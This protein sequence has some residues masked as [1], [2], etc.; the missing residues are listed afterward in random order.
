MFLGGRRFLLA[1]LVSIVACRKVFELVG[2]SDLCS[3]S[4]VFDLGLAEDDVRVRAWTLV[5]VRLL[6]DEQNILRLSDGHSKNSWN[7]FQTEFGH[8]LS[9]F[10]L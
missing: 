8:G 4:Q 2:G 1:R 5:D 6:D 10:F 3:L 9:G 7:L